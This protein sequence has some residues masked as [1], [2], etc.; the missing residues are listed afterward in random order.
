M[1]NFTKC[2]AI[3]TLILFLYPAASICLQSTDVKTING[4]SSLYSQIDSVNSS[5][6]VFN[7]YD[8]DVSKSMLKDG[9][10]SSAKSALINHVK[11]LPIGIHVIIVKFGLMADVI[12]N[13]EIKNQS[14][15]NDII[16]SI[17]WLSANENYTQF[18]E[19][20]KQTK[21]LCYEIQNHYSNPR[22][23]V[24]VISD[25][26]SSPDKSIGKTEYNLQS[27]VAQTLPLQN[28]LNVY[29][30][31]LTAVDVPAVNLA[32]SDNSGLKT[33]LIQPKNINSA[34]EQIDKDNRI[35]INHTDKKRIT[36]S[37]DNNSSYMIYIIISAFILILVI[38]FVPKSLKSIKIFREQQK[39]FKNRINKLTSNSPSN[40]S[41]TTEYLKIT[42][43]NKNSEDKEN[44]I[45]QEKYF[46]LINGS[47]ILVGS[48]PLKCVFIPNCQ[49][50][51]AVLLS[52]KI[53]GNKIFLYN[54]TKEPLT[55]N[56]KKLRPKHFFQYSVKD[57]ISLDYKGIVRIDLLVTR[58]SSHKKRESEQVKRIRE[59]ANI[60]LNK[61]KNT[62]SKPVKGGF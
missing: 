11:E 52:V 62:E 45:S 54:E 25:G 53:N 1:K 20:V 41:F 5:R 39:Q 10:F 36:K 21:L 46:K 18:D 13:K 30:I 29:F 4:Q 28:G 17:Q 23:K 50:V 55:I 2:L 7:I 49:Q 48:D 51:P 56:Q 14:D 43:L 31:K 27:I 37:S 9:M 35:K 60:N 34:L 16:E 15:R 58:V 19:M 33:L 8:I 42:E 32:S 6:Q 26:I 22:I 61:T 12:V 40:N 24:T 59:L 3:I 38:L 44:K 47:R 57:D